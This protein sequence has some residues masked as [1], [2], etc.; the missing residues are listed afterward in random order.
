MVEDLK[1]VHTIE[2]EK[3]GQEKQEQEKQGQEKQGQENTN[4]KL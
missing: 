3:Q 4:K 1:N 2:K